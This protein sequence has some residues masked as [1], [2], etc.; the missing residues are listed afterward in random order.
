L[1]TLESDNYHS[2]KKANEDAEDDLFVPEK[3]DDGFAKQ[4]KKKRKTT[5][6]RKVQSLAAVIESEVHYFL[7]YFIFLFYF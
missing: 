5:S 4:K 7:F 3:E 2:E 6:I 1:E